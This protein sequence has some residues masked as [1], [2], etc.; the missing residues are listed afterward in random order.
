M[1]G[2]W[3]VP[4]VRR[5]QVWKLFVHVFTDDSSSFGKEGFSCLAGCV[6]RD[7]NW[8]DFVDQWDALLGR[9]LLKH[10][11]TSDFLTGNLR[12]RHGKKVEGFPVKDRMPILQEFMD[13]IRQNVEGIILVGMNVAD[14]KA[15][16]KTTVKSLSAPDF[17]FLRLMRLS[18]AL[19]E[20][21]GWIDPISFIFDDNHK[22]APRMY[23]SW[24]HLK[25]RYWQQPNA[26]AGIMFGDDALLPPLQGA[27]VVACGLVRS[28][29]EGKLMWGDDSDFSRIFVDHERR[30]LIPQLKQEFWDEA[31]FKEHGAEFWANTPAKSSSA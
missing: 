30:R 18:R 6:A 24:S 3:Q 22:V 4:G 17:L 12:D 31:A 21:W 9:H 7:S 2:P 16:A 23:S 28:Q 27:D 11:H 15:V 5:S 1:S 14:Y 20:E 13:V 26:F 29:R 25:R 19:M 8:A 10:M